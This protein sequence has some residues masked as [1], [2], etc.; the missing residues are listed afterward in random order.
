MDTV[1]VSTE[2]R[3]RTTVIKKSE[4]GKLDKAHRDH[5]VRFF[6]KP[7][8]PPAVPSRAPAVSTVPA[9]QP[10]QNNTAAM[11]GAYLVVNTALMPSVK[12]GNDTSLQ[13]RDNDNQVIQA[14]MLGTVRAV[15]T[16]R[17]IY[18]GI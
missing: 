6:G 18:K 16:A 10:I 1:F 9:Q 13:L 5:V 17:F 3:G 8:G 12:R 14:V 4:Q 15:N 7:V 2:K 11:P